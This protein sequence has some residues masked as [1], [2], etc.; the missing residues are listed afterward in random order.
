M[1]KVRNCDECKFRT[2]N[3]IGGKLFL[4][5]IQKEGIR[6]YD[7]ICTKGHRPRFYMPKLDNPY[8]TDWGWKRNCEDYE[9]GQI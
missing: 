6:P 5:D 3:Y 2:G 4:E 9:H 1:S 8:D 7:K